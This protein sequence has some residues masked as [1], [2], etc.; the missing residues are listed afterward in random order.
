MNLSEASSA[1]GPAEMAHLVDHGAASC[2]VAMVGRH[3]VRRVGSRIHRDA[4]AQR[5]LA[6]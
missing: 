4:A 3:L 1:G 5:H 2:Q 6:V